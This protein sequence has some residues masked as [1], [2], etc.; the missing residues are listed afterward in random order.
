MTVSLLHHV[1][2]V[3]DDQQFQLV[4]VADGLCIGDAVHIGYL[5]ELR[6]GLLCFGF[7]ALLVGDDL[8]LFEHGEILLIEFVLGDQHIGVVSEVLAIVEAQPGDGE[9]VMILDVYGVHFFI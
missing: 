8:M 9:D 4:V 7:P 6:G 2:Q 5:L 1:D 3:S